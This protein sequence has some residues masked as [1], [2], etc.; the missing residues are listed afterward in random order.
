MGKGLAFPLNRR[1]FLAGVAGAMA[2]TSAGRAAFAAPGQ[3]VV[4]NWG[5]DWNDRTVQF[6]EAPF[7]EKAGYTLVRDLDGFDQ[8]RTKIIAG[9]RLPRAPMD[10]A[11]MD[12]AT[13]F[14]LNALEAVETIDETAVP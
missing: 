2:T 14:E 8:R 7:I 9:R 6:F 1:R 13:A 10:V 11:H 3:I 5:G 4:A 12:D